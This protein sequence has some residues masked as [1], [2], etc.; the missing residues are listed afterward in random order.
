MRKRNHFMI[1]AMSIFVC[2]LVSAGCEVTTSSCGNG[3]CETSETC[4]TCPADCGQ[5]PDTCGNGRCDSSED[6]S[7]CSQD[8]GECPR[9]GDGTCDSGEDCS[10]C[11]ADCDCTDDVW[12]TFS[13]TINGAAADAAACSGVGGA[14]VQLWLDDN[15]D[16]AAD[17]SVDF[18]CSSG[19]GSTDTSLFEAGDTISYA[20]ALLNSSG[21]ILSQSDS[22]STE[23]MSAGNN[24]LGTVDFS[25]GGPASIGF[26][27]TLFG[28]PASTAICS[29]VDASAVQVW[30]DENGDD[31]ADDFYEFGCSAGSGVSPEDFMAGDTVKY[32]FALYATGGD[33]LT[34][35]DAWYTEVLGAGINDLGTVDFTYDIPS[36]AAAA[37]SW[38][39][40]GVLGGEEGDYG[41]SETTEICSLMEGSS[42]QLWIDNDD[43]TVADLYYEADCGDGYGVTPF[44]WDGG[45]GITFA[46]GL[47]NGSGELISQS[48]SWD[49]ATLSTGINDLGSVNFYVGD[50]GPLGVE[51]QWA[52]KID[53]PAYGDCDFP[54]DTVTSMGYLLC[55]DGAAC[56]GDYLYDEVDIDTDPADCREQLDW[57][58]LDY[59]TYTL[60]VDGEDVFSA[61]LWGL[62]CMDLTVNS[63]EPNSNEFTCQVYLTFTP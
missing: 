60:I 26:G 55:Y 49:T 52:D 22:W 40:H 61:V 47:Y 1:A 29:S 15:D 57:D 59:G 34:Q 51:L 50:F 39:I 23:T 42:V 9:C 8:C 63:Y 17:R 54:P 2:L 18:T 12:V 10:S 24:N 32:A 43:D 28:M 36:G 7:T 35:S 13:W 48:D 38:Y 31:A 45:E 4:A 3:T 16:G 25:M 6:C 20:F 27:W 5:C 19:A 30:I 33:I 53:D 58:I 46:F 11:P 14:T 56:E 41:I 21:D 62:E 37:F 44:D